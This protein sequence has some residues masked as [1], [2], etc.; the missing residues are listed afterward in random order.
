MRQANREAIY[1]QLG[2]GIHFPAQV[3]ESGNN[4][5]EEDEDIMTELYFNPASGESCKN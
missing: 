3:T 4:D 1:C 2:E 5:D